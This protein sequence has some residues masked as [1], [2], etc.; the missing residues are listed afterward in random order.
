MKALALAA[1]ML[2][3]AP[4]FAADASSAVPSSPP[5][6]SYDVW[7]FRWDGRRIRET[8]DPQL[9]DHR[10]QPSGRLCAA[11]RPIR[12]LDGDDQCAGRLLGSAAPGLTAAQSAASPARPTFAVW[13][14]RLSDGKWVKDDAHSW[15]TSD[16]VSGL[17]YAHKV[18]AVA[19]WA[20]TTNCPQPLPERSGMSGP[21]CAALDKPWRV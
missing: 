20:A 1:V 21:R 15:T 17:E 13:S 19:G 10:Y 8:S 9:H 7:G 18:Q 16:P 12:R 3:T 11:S 6:V 5:A 14:F 4:I 2:F